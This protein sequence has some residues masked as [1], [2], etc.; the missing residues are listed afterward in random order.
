MKRTLR[1]LALLM[2]YPSETLKAH[3][4]EVRDALDSEAS[5]PA[6]SRTYLAPLL[7]KFEHLPLLE[8]QIDYSG[9]F[10]NSRALS[11][12]FFEH[13]HGESRDRGQAMIDLGEAYIERGF[14]MTREELPDFIPMFLEFVSCLSEDEARDWLSRPSHVF[15]ALLQRLEEC[16]SE[17]AAIFH[18]LLTMAGEKPDPESV[19][20]LVE[21]GRASETKSVDEDWEEEP[22]TFMAS[23]QGRPVS[24]VV[25]KLKAAGKLIMSSSDN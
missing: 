17:Y 21:R 5:L 8:L 13:I 16:Q 7:D 3:I 20:E 4:A 10:D 2:D 14:L 19:R 12:H 11:L 23:T 15:A 24:G 18:G 9:L 22:V 1:A 25:E 6:A